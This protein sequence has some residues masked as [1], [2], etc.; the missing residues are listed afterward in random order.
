MIHACLQ[1]VTK[2]QQ[3][4]HCFGC[5]CYVAYRTV[6][7]NLV[8]SADTDNMSQ[9]HKDVCGNGGITAQFLTSTLNGGEQLTSRSCSF[10]PGERASGDDRGWVDVRAGMDTVEQKKKNTLASARVWTP[11]I[12][13]VTILIKRV[14][15]YLLKWASWYEDV[16]G[17]GIS[18]HILKFGIRLR[19][20]VGQLHVLPT[21]PKAQES[22]WA[23]VS[24]DSKYVVHDRKLNIKNIL[25]CKIS[26]QRFFEVLLSISYKCHNCA[27]P[28]PYLLIIHDNLAVSFDAL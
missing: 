22:G 1:T 26:L 19:W 20:V 24:L 15:L 8:V 17:M 16:W 18:P 2:L 6:G 12:K 28:N 21:L 25:S 23:P 5:R 9:Y 11:T 3:L 7:S 10:I 27:H 13:P 4:P 14:N